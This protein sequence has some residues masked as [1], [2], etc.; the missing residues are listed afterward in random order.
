MNIN[1]NNISET[2]DNHRSYGHSEIMQLVRFGK[3]ETGMKILDLG[4]GTGNLS[5][6][7]LECIPVDMIGIDKSMLM[8]KKARG[9]A[10]QVPV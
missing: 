4:C 6:R 5:V 2:Y 10:L 3:I 9:K 1:Y 7:L 8:L